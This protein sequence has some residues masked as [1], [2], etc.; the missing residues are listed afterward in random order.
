MTMTPGFAISKWSTQHTC[1]PQFVCCA[2]TSKCRSPW[3]MTLPMRVHASLSQD[4]ARRAFSAI[5]GREGLPLLLGQVPPREKFAF[6]GKKNAL[7]ASASVLPA[8][9]DARA[10]RARYEYARRQSLSLS[11]FWFNVQKVR[12][13]LHTTLS[14][15][16][17]SVDGSQSGPASQIVWETRQAGCGLWETVDFGGGE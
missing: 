5:E 12:R 6:A 16:R 14:D 11:R 13:N 7:G 10:A 4:A 15:R 1:V 2:V 3:R 9:P 8:A 17:A